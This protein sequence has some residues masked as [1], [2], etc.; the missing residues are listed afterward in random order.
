MDYEITLV[1]STN[2]T[3]DDGCR[4]CAV[5]LG[6]ATAEDWVA[7][8]RAFE[9]VA[10]HHQG[11]HCLEFWVNTEVEWGR[12]VGATVDRSSGYGEWYELPPDAGEIEEQERTELS[13]MH[14]LDTGVVFS[15]Q[16]ANDDSG[17][18]FES[19]LL[20][21]EKIEKL[22][23]C[24]EPEQFDGIFTKVDS[25]EDEEEEEDGDEEDGDAE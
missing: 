22:A 20:P 19:W 1:C 9:Q 17:V 7:K 3:R 14:V 8:K 21:W 24:V 10:L 6:R 13:T 25:D 16:W 11:L 18:Y 2:D 23:N 15:A 4:N 12:L 5:T